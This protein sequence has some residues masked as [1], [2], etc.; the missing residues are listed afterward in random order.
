MRFLI[1]MSIFIYNPGESLIS[2]TLNV[3]TINKNESA[4][5]LD[6]YWKTFMKTNNKSYEN[7]LTEVRKEIFND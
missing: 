5:E 1:V 3:L 7:P 6:E 2:R 4:S